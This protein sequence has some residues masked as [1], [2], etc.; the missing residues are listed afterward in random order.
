MSG[1]ANSLVNHLAQS[2]RYAT[3]CEE[4]TNPQGLPSSYLQKQPEQQQK[5]QQPPYQLTVESDRSVDSVS[6]GV[7]TPVRDTRGHDE[8]QPSVTLADQT[9]QSSVV[10]APVRKTSI[11]NGD[12]YLNRIV[13]LYDFGDAVADCLTDEHCRRLAKYC[14]KMRD[15]EA[16]DNF[17]AIVTRFMSRHRRGRAEIN[18]VTGIIF[19]L[20]AGNEQPTCCQFRNIVLEISDDKVVG[21]VEKIIEKLKDDDFS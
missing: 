3:P 16:V 8:R 14:V 9:L 2:M 13:D 18:N 11:K 4:S 19:Y 1:D 17:E 5:Q 20:L 15:K 7:S 12:R 6:V 21:K 10:K